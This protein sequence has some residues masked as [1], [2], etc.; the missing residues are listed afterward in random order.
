[1]YPYTDET[2]GLCFLLT[3]VAIN[4]QLSFFY[5]INK[6]NAVKNK[7]GTSASRKAGSE[8]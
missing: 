8:I 7:P 5:H 1:M 4:S 2:D 3:E 6:V